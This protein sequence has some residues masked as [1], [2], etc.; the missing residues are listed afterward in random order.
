MA[1]S[2]DI[3]ISLMLLL[4]PLCRWSVFI[5]GSELELTNVST[6]GILESEV[7]DSLYPSELP[8]SNTL[9]LSLQQNQL[10]TPA[11]L[12]QG[13]VELPAEPIDLETVR[14]GTYTF[15][16]LSDAIDNLNMLQVSMEDDVIKNE[17]PL[18]ICSWPEYIRSVVIQAYY[19]IIKN[20]EPLKESSTAKIQ[21]MNKPKDL[22]SGEKIYKDQKMITLVVPV[23][24]L[25]SFQQCL[26]TLVFMSQHKKVII[27]RPALA[28]I[29]SS[30]LVCDHRAEYIFNFYQVIDHFAKSIQA[31]LEHHTK[32]LFLKMKQLGDKL[33]QLDDLH[34]LACGESSQRKYLVD[35]LKN[36]DLADFLIQRCSCKGLMCI[37]CTAKWINPLKYVTSTGQLLRQ[38]IPQD[39]ML[40]IHCRKDTKWSQE[41]LDKLLQYDT[42]EVAPE[43]QSNVHVPRRRVPNFLRR[44]IECIF[45]F[46][47][48]GQWLWYM[49]GVNMS[50]GLVIALLYI[51]E[52][53]FH[54]QILT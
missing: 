21:F 22:E 18:N 6:I 48:S 44:S 11:L 9:G 40:C 16:E 41:D 46:F 5:L 24:Q 50:V 53:T 47:D 25:P 8:E 42:T 32:K 37:D 28:P 31:K 27:L 33:E 38:N 54:V 12:E 23:D 15:N 2:L 14:I 17:E 52:V 7:A 45:R 3:S 34:C 51:V 36:E 49:I 4:L 35:I 20:E 1:V 26:D 29:P 30:D 13:A 43:V 39:K 19:N 10:Q